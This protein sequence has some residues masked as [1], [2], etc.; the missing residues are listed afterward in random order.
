MKFWQ[1]IMMEFTSAL[2]LQMTYSYFVD[3]QAAP[4]GAAGFAVG[5]M[6][7]MCIMTTQYFSGAAIN[8]SRAIG[9]L[10]FTFDLWA[11]LLYTTSTFAGS[12]AGFFIYDYLLEELDLEMRDLEAIERGEIPPSELLRRRE[13]KAGDTEQLDAD[14]DAAYD[15]PGGKKSFKEDE[16]EA[17]NRSKDE[18]KKE[19]ISAVQ[20]PESEDTEDEEYSGIRCFFDIKIDGNPSGRIVFKLY[21][22]VVPKTTENFRCLC[23]G[24]KGYGTLGKPLSYKD[25]IFHR[26]IP[27]FMLQGGDFTDADGTG[28]E[29]IYGRVFDDENFDRKHTKPGLLSMANSGP[30]S[31]GSQFFITTVKTGWLDGKHVV[32]G[33]VVRGMKLVRK[34]EKFGTKTG[35][36]T[37]DIVISDCGQL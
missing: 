3:N 35:R 31:N 23:T 25:S 27:G 37:A 11:L 7:G 17:L 19:D 15:F 22:D 29:S 20:D 16:D 24:E 13:L 33:E 32:F 5:A 6:F 10:I 14:D 1:V 34:I 8:P 36:T 21:T 28:G 26:V 12:F 18:D 2:F 4:K 9:P 30:N